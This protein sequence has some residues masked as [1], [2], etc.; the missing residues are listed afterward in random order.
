MSGYSAVI[1]TIFA[2][3]VLIFQIDLKDSIL[4]QNFW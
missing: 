4:V 1:A 2:T 3:I